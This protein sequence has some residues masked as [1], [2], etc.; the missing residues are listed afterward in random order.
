[1][2]RPKARL[3]TANE[4]VVY[5]ADVAAREEKI[6]QASQV[7][8]SAED[9]ASK[10]AGAAPIVEEVTDTV[11]YAESAKTETGKTTAHTAS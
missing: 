8:R 5:K 6:V 4:K 2:S 3:A 11:T 7:G 9:S 1:M 10:N